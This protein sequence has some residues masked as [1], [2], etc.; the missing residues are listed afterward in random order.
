MGLRLSGPRNFQG[1]DGETVNII[2]QKRMGG[3]AKMFPQAQKTLAKP[4]KK[5]LNSTGNGK[6]TERYGS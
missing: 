3:Q 5:R 1:I 6:Y 4:G 2:K